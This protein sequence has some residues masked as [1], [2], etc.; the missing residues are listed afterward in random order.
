MLFVKDKEKKI[1][2]RNYIILAIIVILAV[3][4]YSWAIIQL[5]RDFDFG[6]IALLLLPSLIYLWFYRN[7]K[8]SEPLKHRKTAA[9]LF[10]YGLIYFISIFFINILGSSV[11]YW[12]VQ[13]LIPIAILKIC[14]ESLS[15]IFL[16][17]TAVF[18]DVKFV[19]FSAAIIIPFLIFGVRDSEQIIELCQSWK[20]IVYLPLSILYML[21]VVA[22]WEEFFFRGIIL[23]SILKLSNNAS[24]SIFISAL[25]F[26]TYHI[27]MR[28][29]NVK[30]EYYG[31]L[32]A[33]IAST[34]NEQFIMGLFL[35]LIVYKSKNIWHGI[36]LHSILNGISFVY[37]LS[38]MLK[39]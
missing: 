2:K 15:G 38:L 16:K 35:G 5:D 36:W 10:F 6:L 19:I 13:F 28:Y 26:G 1:M 12:L 7:E 4:M 33:S 37:Q 34:I 14:R 25:F 17:W 32:L 31:D 3:A 24:V 29:L 9:F 39:I 18:S 22:F 21:I 8:S 23:N 20:I 30:S 27:P 11:A